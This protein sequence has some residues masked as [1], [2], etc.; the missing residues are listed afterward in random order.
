MYAFDYKTT[1]YVAVCYD[2]SI[3]DKTVEGI[4]CYTDEGY[5]IDYKKVKASYEK[6]RTL[7]WTS[8]IGGAKEIAEPHK[9]NK[10]QALIAE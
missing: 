1:T 2:G 8:V 5:Q 7:I 9:E 4:K 10:M 3:G 6:K